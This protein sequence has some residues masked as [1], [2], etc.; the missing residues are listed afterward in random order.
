MRVLFFIIL[1]VVTAS[2]YSIGKA[3]NAKVVDVRIDSNGFGIVAFDKPITS[4]PAT[5]RNPSY[6]NH[7]SFDTNTAGGKAIYSMA[8]AAA[9]A[10]KSITAYGTGTC[11]EYVNNVE[12]W[13]YGHFFVN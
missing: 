3:D 2:A 4:E 7:F 6:S 13:S 10:G 5:C 8:L 12:S 9:T 1:S 11:S